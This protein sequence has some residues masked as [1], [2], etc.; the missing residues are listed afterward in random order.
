MEF[1]QIELNSTASG[2]LQ[3]LL[4]TVDMFLSV[5]LNNDYQICR[6]W[7]EEL[8]T[9]SKSSFIQSIIF[10]ILFKL[11]FLPASSEFSPPNPLQPAS[12]DRF[13]WAVFWFA[14]YTHWLNWLDRRA[15]LS[16]TRHISKCQRWN[17]ATIP[18]SHQIYSAELA[19][20]IRMNVYIFILF[21]FFVIH[22]Q[23]AISSK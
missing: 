22:S 3:A 6:T 17:A 10:C 14:Y 9:A 18:L 21:N 8:R 13:V 2:M 1:L 15:A 16:N 20:Y 7:P 4:R 11:L 12:A 5:C 19:G 23:F